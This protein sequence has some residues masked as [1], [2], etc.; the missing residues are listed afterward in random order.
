MIVIYFKKGRAHPFF[1]VPMNEIAGC[2]LD[3]DLLWGKLFGI[4]RERLLETKDPARRFVLIEEF[5]LGQFQSKLDQNP[6]VEYALDQIV[7]TPNQ[8]S[9]GKLNDS[10]GYSQK[11]FINLFKSKVGVTPKAYL[12]IMRFQKAITEIEQIQKV[13]WSAIA[14]DCGFYDQAHLIN[15]FRAFSGFTPEE[16]VRSKSELLN[17]VPVG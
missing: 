12:R 1:P 17:Y 5:L 13:D 10:L 8:V 14:Q 2:V 11:H 3:A 6:V 16:Y 15:D 4:L 7:A 9:L